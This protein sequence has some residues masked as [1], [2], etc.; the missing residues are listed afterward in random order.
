MDALTR[1]VAV[2]EIKELK[3]RYFRTLDNKDWD[4]FAAVFDAE[5]VMDMRAELQH[6]AGDLAADLLRDHDPVLVGRDVIVDFVRNALPASVVSVHHGHM[7][8]ID[9]VDDDHA[10]GIWA[11]DDFLDFGDGTL[12][13]YGHYHEEY[14]RRSEGAW[15]ISRLQLRR[16]RVDVA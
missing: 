9:V 10:S 5:A 1:L 6:H 16:L 15:S 3:A 7:P 11:M 13:G 12:R 14:R 8:E 4:G 2:E